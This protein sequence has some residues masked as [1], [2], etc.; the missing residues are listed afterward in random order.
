[1]NAKLTKNQNEALENLRENTR[2]YVGYVT[3]RI[4]RTFDKLVEKGFAKVTDSS[5]YG[6]HF[7][8]INA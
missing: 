2:L 5:S 8:I 3:P 4:M 7:E 6:K 1:M